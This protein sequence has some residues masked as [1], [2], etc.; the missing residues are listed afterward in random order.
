MRILESAALSIDKYIARVAEL[1]DFSR[2]RIAPGTLTK[3]AWPGLI[4][5]LARQAN[6]GFIGIIGTNGKH[7]TCRILAAI[8]RQ[9]DARTLYPEHITP[10]IDDVA[11]TLV[12]ATDTRG[13]IQADYG[14]FG[15]ETEMLGQAIRLCSPHTLVLSNLYEDEVKPEISPG[16][17]I[18][19]WNN[20]FGDMPAG[21][22][23]LVNADDPNLTG[24]FTRGVPPQLIYFGVEDETLHLEHGP[25]PVVPCQ[26][27]GTS[28]V[29]RINC[30]GHLGDYACENCRWERPLPTIYAI[31]VRLETERSCFRLI[32]PKG[33]LDVSLPLS[34][35]HNVYNA[36]AA[37]A[38]AF[39]LGLNPA[40]I[41]MGLETVK[42]PEGRDERVL[43]HGR[44]ARLM[45]IKNRT[46]LH[47]SLRTCM[48]DNKREHYLFLLDNAVHEGSN[49]PWIEDTDLEGILDRAKSFH[50][51]GS[52]GTHLS[53]M[54][55]QMD[56]EE[57]ALAMDAS[58][59]FHDIMRRLTPGD[60]LWVLATKN[61]MF[62][63][64]QE[65]K[66]MGIQ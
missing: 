4:Q 61:T 25:K 22:N 43:I 50:L 42:P 28:L 47:E 20:W 29:Y 12:Q 8:L 48:L 53:L 39:S 46:S 31:D 58:D 49:K 2:G 13:M 30:L 27:C 54:N 5:S 66:E 65:L 26:R 34:G 11:S 3:V 16:K 62:I 38:T 23:I 45:V 52:G 6:E 40:A 33:P 44:E 51:A 1:F 60:R 55:E 56:G 14:I 41:R 36:T 35:L 24:A 7:T 10:S 59:I 37:A 32:T 17:L 18:G 19:D 21:N 64:R 57:M 63:I 15:F 9:S